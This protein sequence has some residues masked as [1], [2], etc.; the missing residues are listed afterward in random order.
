MDADLIGQ[1]WTQA[2][3]HCE[4]CRR[5]QEFDELPFEVDHIIATSH[6]G[7]T[8]LGNLALSC[9]ACNRHKGYHDPR[10]GRE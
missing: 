3:S 7:R 10:A 8:V 6:G 2:N 1:I 9:F 4:Y 5:P